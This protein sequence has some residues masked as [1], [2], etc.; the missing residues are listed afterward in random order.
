MRE[1]TLS[2]STKLTKGGNFPILSDHSTLFSMFI[3]QD[4]CSKGHTLEN[5]S[6][7]KFLSLSHLVPHS[8]TPNQPNWMQLFTWLPLFGYL[9]APLCLM[10]LLAGMLVLSQICL[11][12]YPLRSTPHSPS[13]STGHL[14]SPWSSLLEMCSF[15]T[16]H[17]AVN[18]YIQIYF[19]LKTMVRE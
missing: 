17:I 6:P 16:Y 12:C 14:F 1:H 10:H 11:P 2:I 18:V 19:S 15:L 3:S 7:S 4:Y 5:A 9:A 8:P 13:S